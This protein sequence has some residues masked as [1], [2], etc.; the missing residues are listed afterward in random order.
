MSFFYRLDVLIYDYLKKRK[1]NQAA[2]SLLNES[3]SLVA[4]SQSG[5]N[6]ASAEGPVPPRLPVQMD[7]ENSILLEWFAQ[8]WERWFN[9]PQQGGGVNQ[10]GPH[11]QPSPGALASAR[12][13]AL[14][15]AG[16]LAGALAGRERQGS[17]PGMGMP[18]MGAGSPTG[19]TA[20]RIL[21][22]QSDSLR[23]VMDSLGMKHKDVDQLDR[24]D[25]TRIMA[26][27]TA[28]SGKQPAQVEDKPS[29]AQPKQQQKQQQQQRGEQQ[30]QQHGKQGGGR[31]QQHRQQQESEP[32]QPVV[33]EEEPE[34]GRTRRPRRAAAIAAAAAVAEESRDHDDSDSESSPPSKRRRRGSVQEEDGKS[35]S[36]GQ[37]THEAAGA[38][39]ATKAAANAGLQDASKPQPFQAF[40][41]SDQMGHSLPLFTAEQVMAIMSA[42][43][44]NFAVQPEAL[45]R[46]QIRK[47]L[48]TDPRAINAFMMQ[49]EAD[50]QAQ[51]QGQAFPSS[52]AA[53]LQFQQQRQRQQQAMLSLG[54]AAGGAPGQLG[55]MGFP[56]LA[57]ALGGSDI[58]SAASIMSP[59]G[60]VGS[61]LYPGV[62]PGFSPDLYG[63]L[64][65]L[66]Q[67]GTG[68]QGLNANQAMQIARH[69]ANAE[70]FKTMGQRRA[71]GLSGLPGGPQM[72]LPL[73]GPGATPF[74]G[75]MGSNVGS[76]L[77]SVGGRAV[78]PGS[79]SLESP[80]MSGRGPALHQQPMPGATVQAQLRQQ[81]L[82]MIQQQQAGTGFQ[83]GMG[84]MGQRSVA[85]ESPASAQSPAGE[86]G[87]DSRRK[88]ADGNGSPSTPMSPGSKKAPRS[89]KAPAK[90]ANTAS[91]EPKKKAPRPPPRARNV[92][93]RPWIIACCDMFSV[94]S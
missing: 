94:I 87:R 66:G 68:G 55:S 32:N 3:A 78:T 93:S 30:N 49:H 88:G 81:Q 39:A 82:I 83:G 29:S 2:A 86:S 16:G 15:Q 9:L 84:L 52:D 31:Q 36:Q 85:N 40:Q 24:Q 57:G 33:K 62:R 51:A 19:T 71:A 10:P 13:Q 27:Q 17:V 59:T 46:E 42:R 47:M 35:V 1:Y 21:N 50:F 76:P 80:D 60:S 38:H 73:G 22:L 6:A 37:L 53:F 58:G 20:S 18:A 54:G 56:N 45:K 89:R 34:E 79:G 72:S 64:G 90:A 70:Q 67:G 26:N 11:T 5:S 44:P 25:L 4:Q 77:G 48:E 61:P 63:A 74:P 43:D 12:A 7:L 65:G 28:G 41:R 91:A 23:Q 14:S 8:G 75:M 69:A 92:S